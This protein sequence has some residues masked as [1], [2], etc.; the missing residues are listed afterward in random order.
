LT[1]IWTTTAGQYG[2]VTFDDLLDPETN[3][4]FS[5]RH[6]HYLLKRYRGNLALSLYSWNRGQGTV[7]RLLRYGQPPNNGYGPRVYKAAMNAG[8]PLPGK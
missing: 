8:R 6:L 3:I 2:E 7:D 4:D 5:F 1:Q